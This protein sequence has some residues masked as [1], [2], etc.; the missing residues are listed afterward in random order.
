[1]TFKAFHSFTNTISTTFFNTK[2]DED[3]CLST[4]IKANEIDWLD[5]VI[6]IPTRSKLWQQFL[7]KLIKTRRQ[8]NWRI[9]HNW[10]QE[11]SFIVYP[12]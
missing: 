6:E 11:P 10:Q 3:E 9:K 12:R 8:F 1:V 4:K 5:Q 7:A 2:H